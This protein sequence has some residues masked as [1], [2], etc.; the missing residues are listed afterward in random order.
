MS[1][2]SGERMDWIPPASQAEFDIVIVI[3][4]LFQSL[5]NKTLARFPERFG[6]PFKD[7][8]A[9]SSL[10]ARHLVA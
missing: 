5:R 6:V 7:R 9:S 2:V 3:F 10:W 4:R 1:R 8:Q